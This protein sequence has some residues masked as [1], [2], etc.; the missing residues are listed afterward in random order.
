ML[1]NSFVLCLFVSLCQLAN[2]EANGDLQNRI[3]TIARQ[4]DS[5]TFS[6][7]QTTRKEV[8]QAIF[9]SLDNVN[10]AEIFEPQKALSDSEMI[11]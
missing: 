8:A 10:A 4:A 11:Y 3:N 6:K 7:S 2:A 9:D 5:L 1:K